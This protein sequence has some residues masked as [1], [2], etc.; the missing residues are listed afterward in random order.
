MP[1]FSVTITGV[2]VELEDGHRTMAEL[3]ELGMSTLKEAYELEKETIAKIGKGDL[4][5]VGFHN[6]KDTSRPTNTWRV[7]TVN[8]EIKHG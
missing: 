5:A 8:P 6:E 1:K 4:T 3:Q 7:A 2:N